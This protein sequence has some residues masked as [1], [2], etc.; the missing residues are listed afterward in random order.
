MCFDVNFL[1]VDFILF[2]FFVLGITGLV[3]ID[4]KNARDIDVDLW[5]MTNQETGEFG[6]SPGVESQKA[7]QC[8]R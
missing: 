4:D 7:A 3:T 6:V 5:A 1:I 2:Y 8:T